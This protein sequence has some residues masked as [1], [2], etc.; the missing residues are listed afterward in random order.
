MV[1][2]PSGTVTFLVTDIEGSTRLW[3]AE[4]ERMQPA[5]A[6][7]DALL[8]SV[9]EET[10]GYVFKTVGDASCAAFERAPDALRTAL[11]AQRRLHGQAL[12]GATASRAHGAAHGHRRGAGRG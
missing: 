1:T 7:H 5:L 12:G 4:P 3:D 10:G 6:R 2:L 8:R 11:Q 9:I